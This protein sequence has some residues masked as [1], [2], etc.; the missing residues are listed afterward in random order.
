M[1]IF[2]VTRFF[3]ALTVL[4][5]IIKTYGYSFAAGWWKDL[6]QVLFRL[7]DD[8]K[9]P[10]NH[11]EKAEWMTTTCSHALFS[12]VDVMTQYFDPLGSLLLDDVYAQLK[13]CITQG[14]LSVPCVTFGSLVKYFF[15][16]R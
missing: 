16:R 13:W 12:I 6:F 10:Q 8:L 3:R 4:F 2:M 1:I 11:M 14:R 15:L 9:L 5:E 7:F